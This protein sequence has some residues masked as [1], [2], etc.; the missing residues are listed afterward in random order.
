MHSKKNNI[1]YF[2]E[3]SIGIIDLEDYDDESLRCG[4]HYTFPTEEFS[5]SNLIAR[6]KAIK[7][8]KTFSNYFERYDPEDITAFEAFANSGFKTFNKLSFS[9]IEYQCYYT[10]SVFFITDEKQKGTIYTGGGPGQIGYDMSV[11]DNQDTVFQ[12]L[13]TEYRILKKAGINL[14]KEEEVVTY[15]DHKEK[16]QKKGLILPNEMDWTK[17]ES[18][19]IF[20]F[21]LDS[22][23]QKKEDKQEKK[24]VE[25]H[26]TSSKGLLKIKNELM[27][28]S[29]KANNEII[30]EFQK[31]I[32]KILKKNTK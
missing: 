7:C 5:S 19:A 26:S 6:K 2:V 14:R 28:I 15:Y 32:Y 20:S 9:D 8:A 29:I 30:A 3:K 4:W 13:Q 10:V 18:N 17:Y 27:E 16:K 12:D 23:E 1:K 25:K 22:D 31:T 11:G 21:F 24:V